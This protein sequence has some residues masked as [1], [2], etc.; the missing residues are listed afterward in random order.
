MPSGQLCLV[1]VPWNGH[2]LGLAQMRHVARHAYTA[3]GIS[4]TSLPAC[5]SGNSS[6]ERALWALWREAAHAAVRTGH[7]RARHLVGR[8]GCG[9]FTRCV[10]LPATLLRPFTPQEMCAASLLRCRQ[11][12]M[13]RVQK[14]ALKAT[15]QGNLGSSRELVCE[16]YHRHCGS[17]QHANTQPALRC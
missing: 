15:S 14:A 10:S 3:Q 11:D 4:C 2:N 16:S 6:S 5:V 1:L 9:R 13:N 8:L 7:T 12:H 17:R